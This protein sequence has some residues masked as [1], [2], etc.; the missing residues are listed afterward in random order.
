MQAGLFTP[1]ATAPR[2]GRA[3]DAAPT[4]AAV[5]LFAGMGLVRRALESPRAQAEARWRTVFAN[6]FDP[7]KA[8]L[9]RASFADAGA[10]FN[11]SDVGSLRG[12]DVPA[13][14]L[15]TASFP[16]TDLSLAGGRAGIHAGQ[17]GAVW[18]VLRLL[19]E[20][21]VAE[22]PELL[23]FE[24]V[25]GLL[26]SRS[27]ASA[28]GEAGSDLHAL[29][30][31]L[32][33]VGYGVDP[34]V[35][36]AA[37]FTAQSRERVYLLCAPLDALEAM[38]GGLLE[39]GRARP[40]AVVEAVRRGVGLRWHARPLPDPPAHGATLRDV[41][42]DPPEDSTRWWSVDRAAYF[43]S[44]IHPA[45]QPTARRMIDS[46]V[47]THATAFR[48]VRPVGPGGAKR[49][50]VELRT[51]GLAGCLRLPKGGSA[52]QIVFRA[53]RGR[54]DVRYMTPRECAA[55]QGVGDEPLFR[56]DR[57]GEDAFTDNEL[58][59]GL[60]DAVCVPAARWALDALLI[61]TGLTAR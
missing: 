54:F 20:T 36:D 45:H 37:W 27:G 47:T 33:G 57:A 41:I 46:S 13:T 9:Y 3:S 1:A 56:E 43:L 12:G 4:R 32:N 11:G 8:R 52:K 38:D 50:V 10:V 44:Q 2:T 35:V 19:G 30:R 28:A 51:D 6:D 14:G 31:G 29:V 59:T 61:G 24:N 48:R 7:L 18:H 53:G 40:R 17:S 42:H 5:E 58:L 55:L 21:R 39:M 23:L 15:W 22:R 26:S 60:G 49:S 25:T 34:I 16:C